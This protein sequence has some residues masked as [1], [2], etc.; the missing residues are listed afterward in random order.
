MPLRGPRRFA[1]ATLTSC[2][3][4]AARRSASVCLLRA[5][6]RARRVRYA[7]AR[8]AGL[9]PCSTKSRRLRASPHGALRASLGAH[10]V[11]Q[12]HYSRA[13]RQGACAWRRVRRFTSCRRP[14]ESAD[15][16]A[17]GRYGA[18]CARLLWRRCLWR[19]SR[20]LLQAH[21]PWRCGDARWTRAHSSS[22]AG[23]RSCWR[24]CC[25]ARSSYRASRVSRSNRASALKPRRRWNIGFTFDAAELACTAA[26]PADNCY[27]RHMARLDGCVAFLFWRAP[28]RVLPCPACPERSLAGLTLD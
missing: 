12:R 2:A 19:S 10:G 22:A 27:P 3:Q 14:R 21:R 8:R 9:K 11:V 6:S 16:P 26:A 1:P 7:R 13:R 17:R 24:L 4:A 20:M 15:A 23:T 5:A 28:S 25:T 18:P